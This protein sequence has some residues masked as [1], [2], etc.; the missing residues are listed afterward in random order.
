MGKMSSTLLALTV[1]SEGQS[2]GED[3][4]DMK[5]RTSMGSVQAMHSFFGRLTDC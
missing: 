4:G 5:S 2:R 3:D 1:R